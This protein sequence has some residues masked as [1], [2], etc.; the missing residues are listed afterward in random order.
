MLTPAPAPRIVRS[1]EAFP[2]MEAE[3][4]V[5]GSSLAYASNGKG[6]ET[7]VDFDLGQPTQ[8]GGFKHVDRP[9]PATI[10]TAQ[11]IFSDYEDFSEPIRTVEVDHVNRPGGTTFARFEPV[12]AR[13]V[14]WQVTAI[15]AHACS[16]G[17]EI[18][19]YATADS[20]PTPKQTSFSAR[21]WPALAREEGR[22]MLPLSITFCDS[23]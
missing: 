2:N 9:D 21:A 18:T 16:G 3:R 6:T 14:R 1:A 23:E 13:Y 10:D 11:L 19:F 5:D 22:L 20:E 15:S 8:I 7:F 4:L 17:T 12:T